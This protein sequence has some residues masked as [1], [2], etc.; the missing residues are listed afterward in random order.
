MAV[1]L[2]PGIYPREI[3]LSATAA[4]VGPL[5]PGFVGTAKKGPMNTPVFVT[6]A[7]QAI[8]TFGEPFVESYL[9]YAVLAFLEEGNQCYIMRVGV[10]CEDGQASS[11]ADICIDTSGARVSGW[12]RIPVFT[13]IDYGRINLRAI[14][15]DNP[16]VIHA[17]SISTPVYNDADVS[18]TNG[19]TSASMATTGTYTGAIDDSFVMVITSPPNVS[20]NAKVSGAG[21][22]IVRNSDGAIVASGTFSDP[23]ATGVS[24]WIVVANGVS[25][26]VTVTSGELDTND[27][28]SFSVVPD[29]RAFSVSVEGASA[30]TY[31]MTAATYTSVTTF[32]AALNTLIGSTNYVG[33]SATLSDGTVVPQLRT[34]VAGRW[35]QILT[36]AAWALEVGQVQ[37]AWDIPRS[38]LIGTEVGPYDITTQS[39]RVALNVVGPTATTL[40]EFNAP[41]GGG[42]TATTLASAIDLAGIVDGI[43]LFD[44]FVLTLPDGSARVVIIV[45][46]T[47]NTST[48]QLLADYTH[49]K[50]LRFAETLGIDYP[51]KRS[52]RG[53]SDTRVSLPDTG[54]STSATPLSCETNPLSS[55]CAADSSY[56]D[57]IVGWFVAPSPGTWL[58]DH[59]VTLDLFTGG[60][61]DSAG[62]YKVIIKDNNGVTVDVVEDVSFDTSATRF[63]SNLVNPRSTLGGTDG[64]SY[65]NWESRPSFLNNDPDASDYAVRLPSQFSN[66]EFSGMADGIPTDPAYSSELDAAVIG[67]PAISS[68][69]F[70]FQ[71]PEAINI[72]L[73]ATPG[74]SSGAVIGTALQMCEARGDVLYIV[75]P[76]FGLRPQQVVDWHNGMLLSDLNAAIDSSYGALYWGWVKIYDQFSR[77]EVWIPPSGHIMGIFSR[78]SRESESWSVP[79]GT[80]RG[81][82]LSAI[83][84]EYSP[85]LG[86]RDLLYGSG[87]AVNALVKFPQEGITV[88][89]QKTLLR[90][91]S[92]TNR[93]SVRMLLIEIKKTLSQTLRS[94]IFE[95]N[96]QVLWKQVAATINPYLADIQSRRGLQAYRVVVDQTNNTPQRVGRKELWVSI[97]LMPTQA[98]EF[99]VLNL[100]LL[101]N[102]GSFSAD[103]V[104]AA[105]G[106]VQSQTA[107]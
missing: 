57:N 27:T 21:Y 82:V 29:N 22:Q 23:G 52:Y 51:Y 16:I 35:L 81:R 31:T 1:Y 62:R 20:D 43:N 77:Q 5:R 54:A 87:N 30:T 50:T 18:T 19:A 90:S 13:G 17:S 28:F 100:V 91:E 104:L 71:N 48:L 2:S 39:N 26:R 85:G 89:G 46:T 98:V 79:A 68:G 94:F 76:P 73:I 70:A 49:L 58:N 10:E 4:A 33:V 40:V 34:T 95:P 53:Y 97:F 80:R 83:D 102:G 59:T 44:S 15:S 88:W 86:E 3:D 101:R 72:N 78:T 105:G 25:V 6:N 103:E 93:V 11:L 69:L 67:N 9:M 38:Y 37:Y 42:Q 63:I 75:D 60:V 92:S 12:G 74:F 106:I 107:T 14:D 36:T 55:D 56:F 41:V 32:L 66:K 99:I 61:G 84:V 47:Y 65:V 96:D 45:N 24:A 64:N 7:P 8:D